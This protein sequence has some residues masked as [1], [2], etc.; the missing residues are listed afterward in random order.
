MKQKSK[1]MRNTNGR[2]GGVA[3]AERNDDRGV[4]STDHPV[5]AAIGNALEQLKAAEPT[6][7]PATPRINVTEGSVT[8][9]IRRHDMWE[10]SLRQLDE[11]AERIK[12]NPDIHVMLRYPKRT[13][14]VS[15]PVR[16]DNGRVQVFQG[17]R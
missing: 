11:V 15:V 12:L 9:V 5:A 13:L 8:A 1:R 17:Y 3:T 10:Q 2:N 7:V 6:T 14:E 16:M 4:T